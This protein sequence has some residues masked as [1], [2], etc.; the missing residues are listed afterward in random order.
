MISKNKNELRL[1]FCL[2]TH[3]N[4][5]YMP[6]IKRNNKETQLND[7]RRERKLAFFV[8]IENNYR[9]KYRKSR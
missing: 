4:L 6:H 7:R 9:E 1:V 5:K 3:L 8:I 2:I